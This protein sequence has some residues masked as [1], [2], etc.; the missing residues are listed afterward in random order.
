MIYPDYAAPSPAPFSQYQGL[1]HPSDIRQQSLNPRPMRGKR[2][3][4]IQLS[5]ESRRA[6]TGHERLKEPPKGAEELV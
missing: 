1:P 5:T 3:A 2:T 4:D 6:D